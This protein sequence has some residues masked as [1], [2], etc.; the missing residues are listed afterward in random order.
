MSHERRC[1]TCTA[2]LLSVFGLLFAK[3]D[4]TD[5]L[6][7]VRLPVSGPTS[8][9]A[10]E[11]FAQ[12]IFL[13]CAR[14][15]IPAAEAA[16]VPASRFVSLLVAEGWSVSTIACRD[17]PSKPTLKFVDVLLRDPYPDVSALTTALS[18]LHQACGGAKEGFDALA[19]AGSM[20]TFLERLVFAA[21]EAH[22]DAPTE[23]TKD[24]DR[25]FLTVV[26]GEV[27]EYTIP[28]PPPPALGGD[29]TPSQPSTLATIGASTALAPAPVGELDPPTF[30][31][32][33]PLTPFSVTAAVAPTAFTP[34]VL[35]AAPTAATVPPYR[36][37]TLAL[38]PGGLGARRLRQVQQVS[39]PGHAAP[40]FAAALE[41]LPPRLPQLPLS[42]VEG[43]V[44]EVLP[45]AKMP[46]ALRPPPQAPVPPPPPSAEVA[47]P[48]TPP[49]GREELVA[50]VLPPA[51]AEEVPLLYAEVPVSRDLGAPPPT[52]PHGQVRKRS[53][54]SVPLPPRPRSLHARADPPIVMME[55]DELTNITQP[56]GDLRRQNLQLQQ[57]LDNQSTLMRALVNRFN[58]GGELRLR[59][60]LNNLVTMGDN[61]KPEALGLLF[62]SVSKVIFKKQGP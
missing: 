4:E 16:L 9:A 11:P 18:H 55:W 14:F 28:V 36:F 3:P 45:Q 54:L 27:T 20:L 59:A 57:V 62:S 23:L 56:L 26:F 34:G 50:E 51:R 1:A 7:G 60:L 31:L 53:A 58:L 22:G 33:A 19:A 13:L 10:E 2:G 24:C 30:A 37:G 41:P 42:L 8:I 32:T 48:P 12:F 44:A 43:S 61:L 52:P 49:S 21:R 25:H 5:E 46:A 35:A 29:S 38:I 47:P 17:H 39:T 6:M 40:L 15:I